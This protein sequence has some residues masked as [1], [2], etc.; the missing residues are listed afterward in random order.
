MALD[1]SE[2]QLRKRIDKATFLIT[3]KHHQDMVALHYCPKT[4]DQPKVIAILLKGKWHPQWI[5][6]KKVYEVPNLFNRL[7]HYDLDADITP[8]LYRSVAVVIS[9]HKNKWSNDLSELEL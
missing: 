4:M 9:V 6:G 3:D 5:K 2:D 7:I 1:I 8:D